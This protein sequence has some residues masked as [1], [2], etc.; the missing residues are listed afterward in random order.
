MNKGVM[1]VYDIESDFAYQF[2]N[3]MTQKQETDIKM[4][5]FT[6]YSALKEFSL[7][8]NIDILLIA[9]G[10]LKD[11]IEELNADMVIV[12]SE[13]GEFSEFKAVDKYQNADS[14]F[15]EVMEYVEEETRTV[16]SETTCL[17]N[18]KVIGVYSPVRRCLKTTF[19]L[20][21][22]DILAEKGKTLY[23]NFEEY[24]GLRKVLKAD[25]IGDLSDLMYFYIQNQDE[26][27]NK[28]TKIKQSFSRFDYIPPMMFSEELRNIDVDEWK[29]MIRLLVESSRYNYFVLDLSEMITNI[30]DIL[31]I[32]DEIY[33]PILND[34]ISLAK[35]NEFEQVLKD[36]HKENIQDSILKFSMRGEKYIEKDLCDEYKIINGEFRDYVKEIMGGVK[37]I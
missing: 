27:V 14:V 35:V 16:N 24:S 7:S 13:G 5:A 1:A 26:F 23:I 2:V 17:A 15:R 6:D 3:Y 20:A 33:M 25:Y 12:L 22:S 30:S 37:N 31:E 8:N 28:V 21:L 18:K 36:R 9:E 29:M 19:S 10:V 34:F 4:Y 32:C 11:R